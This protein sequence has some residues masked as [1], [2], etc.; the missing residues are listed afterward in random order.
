M[1]NL[2]FSCRFLTE[3]LLKKQTFF[4]SIDPRS[5]FAQINRLVE[6]FLHWNTLQEH[7]NDLPLQFQTH[8]PRPWS[9]INWHGINC[10]QIVGVNP[11]IFL[12]VI[13]GSMEVCK[14][15]IG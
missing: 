9:A 8:K 12:A 13:R 3:N 2:S 15:S 4:Q 10:S 6:E 1:T 7:L 11:D 14:H 5:R